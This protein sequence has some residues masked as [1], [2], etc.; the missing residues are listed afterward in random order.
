MRPLIDFQTDFWIPQIPSLSDMPI[1]L[2]LVWDDL[3]NIKYLQRSL[4]K[5]NAT[6]EKKSEEDCEEKSVEEKNREAHV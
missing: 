5:K 4:R 3:P 1:A 6:E 2:G